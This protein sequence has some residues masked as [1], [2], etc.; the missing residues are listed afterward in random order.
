MQA[1]YFLHQ[2]RGYFYILPSMKFLQVSGYLKHRKNFKVKLTVKLKGSFTSKQVG[3][4]P[5][6]LRYL[7]NL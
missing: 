2:I 6:A 1:A 7:R 3:H 4:E 5:R